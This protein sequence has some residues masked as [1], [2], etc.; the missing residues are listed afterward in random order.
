MTHKQ[1]TQLF[2]AARPVEFLS[3]DTLEPLFR[4]TTGNPEVFLMSDIFP[5]LM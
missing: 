1:K 4:N 3:M 2:A 5:K